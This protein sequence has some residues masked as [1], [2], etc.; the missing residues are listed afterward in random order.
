MT[1]SVAGRPLASEYT[2]YYETY[3]GKVQGDDPL[4]ALEALTARTRRV[5]ESIPA[6]KAGFRYADGKWTV[7]DV[8]G[9]MVDA[10]RVFAFRALWFA[11]GDSNPLPGFD[12]NAWVPAA[13]L[14]AVSLKDIIDAWRTQRAAT[15]AMLKTFGPDAWTRTG[16]ANNKVMSVR[17]LAFTIA[18]H[19]IHHL[20]VLGERYGVTA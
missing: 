12:E 19:E 16:T 8:I 10:E 17:A 6:G 18:G 2:P 11:R 7:R 15:I 4:A 1:P 20:G 14:D 3:I 9:H 5:L 13:R